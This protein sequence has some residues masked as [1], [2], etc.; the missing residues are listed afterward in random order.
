MTNAAKGLALAL[1][2]LTTAIGSAEA[3]DLKLGQSPKLVP[4]QVQLGIIP[5]P[6]NLCPGPAKLTAWVQTNVPGTLDILIVRKNGQVAG[7]YA[8]TTVKGGNGV[9]I[10]SYTRNLVVGTP[11]DAEYRVVVAGTQA[12][13]N[14]VPLVADC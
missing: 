12:A 4:T 11:I 2:A 14:W 9:V 13:S 6:D 1:I 3:F 5:P 8:V 10:G 7:P